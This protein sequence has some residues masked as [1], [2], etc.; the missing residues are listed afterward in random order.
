MTRLA[1]VL[2]LAVPLFA[3]DEPHLWCVST[4][5][6]FDL[7]KDCVERWDLETPVTPTNTVRR[8][9]WISKG[10][11][12]VRIGIIP[13]RATEGDMIEQMDASISVEESLVGPPDADGTVIV[14]EEKLGTWRFTLEPYW[15]RKGRLHVVVPQGDWRMRMILG[16][17]EM[18][19]PSDGRVMHV[20]DAT[21]AEEA[22]AIRAR[23][24]KRKKST[25]SI[26]LRG[27]AIGANGAAA[28]FAKIRPDCRD[29]ICETAHDGTFRCTMRRPETNAL[30]IDHPRLGRK[31]IELGSRN[32]ETDLGTIELLAGG[33]IR[34]VKPIHVELPEGTTLALLRNRKEVRE[35]RPFD[36]EV[37]EFAGVEAD[38]YDLLLAGPEPLQRKLIPVR[39]D[40]DAEVEHTLS[41]DAF[42]LTGD[43]EYRDAGLTDAKIELVGEAW[44]ATLETDHS[45]RFA[46]ELWSDGDYSVVVQSGRLAQPY[47]EMRHA[48]ASD[49]HWSLDIPSRRIHGRVIDAE[50]SGPVANATIAITSNA[51]ETR[52]SRTVVAEPD[53]SFDISGIAEGEYTLVPKAPGFLIAEPAELRVGKADG[54]LR[55][56]LPLMRGSDVRIVVLDGRGAP[57]AGATV[58]CDLTPDGTNATRLHR[59]GEN[60]V[61][62]V[63]LPKRTMKNVYIVPERG[64]LAIARVS[65]DASEVRVVVPDAVAKLTLKARTTAGEPLPGLRYALRYAGEPVPP[66]VLRTMAMMRSFPIAT[67]A[68]GTASIPLLP[69]GRYD[70]SL[71]DAAWAAVDAAAGETAITQ[72]FAQR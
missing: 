8:Y 13:P 72:T 57:V 69:A 48:S 36:R 35:P 40:G 38:R 68:T 65:A 55:L 59:T 46:A 44:E 34:I 62:V 47:G 20:P 11:D 42:K 54:D 58:V 53:G 12:A 14:S 4:T 56:D 45:G 70:V 16:G 71:G 39:V 23:L 43:V 66:F 3:Y 1:L 27:K 37:V 50:R 67:D 19:Y 24:A 63:S 17:K 2:L 18:P 25:N 29:P 33:T 30:C 5:G 51:R 28:D 41:L 32:T 61:V 22:A 60:G 15:F 10:Q 9:L 21:T 7:K 64:S 6:V 31:R 49:S 26:T 52:W